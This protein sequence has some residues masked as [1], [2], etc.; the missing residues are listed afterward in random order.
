MSKYLN[1]VIL[2]G[3]VGKDPETKILTGGNVQATFS[4]ATSTGGYTGKDG[5]EI[6]EKTQW[7]NIVVWGPQASV[8]EKYIKKGSKLLVKGRIEYRDYEKDGQKRYITGIIANDLMLLSQPMQAAPQPTPQ[9]QPMGAPQ[10]D[11]FSDILP[12]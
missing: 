3:N 8:V 5:K 7:H 11:P 10:Q 12:F 6:P 2:A 9:H 4:L 1:E